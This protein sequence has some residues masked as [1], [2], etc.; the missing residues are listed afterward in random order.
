MNQFVEYI[1]ATIADKISC[2]PVN[3]VTQT[4]YFKN[5]KHH[6]VIR[7]IQANRLPQI[8]ALFTSDRTFESVSRLTHPPGIAF[9]IRQELL[10]QEIAKEVERV[11]SDP[12]DDVKSQL[13]IFIP[14]HTATEF[15]QS[16]AYAS[17][18]A[19]FARRSYERLGF[20]VHVKCYISDELEESALYDT[21]SHKTRLDFLWKTSGMEHF[22]L[23]L[24]TLH[25]TSSVSLQSTLSRLKEIDDSLCLDGLYTKLSGNGQDQK[26]SSLNVPSKILVMTDLLLSYAPT[27]TLLFIHPEN[28]NSSFLKSRK[29]AEVMGGC[30]IQPLA[31]PFSKITGF[32]SDKS[33]ESPA[34]TPSNLSSA[35]SIAIPHVKSLLETSTA[36][37]ECEPTITQIS[38]C[39]STLCK[40]AILFKL[41]QNRRSTPQHYSHK[42][43]QGDIG[44]YVQYTIA[45]IKGIARKSGVKPCISSS[46]S[47]CTLPPECGEIACILSQYQSILSASLARM[48]VSMLISYLCMLSKKVTS[49]TYDLRV[50]GVDRGGAERLGLFM[51]VV[52]VLEHGLFIVGGLEGVAWM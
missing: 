43:S 49:I 15:I 6:L 20:S 16:H 26:N 36:V 45:K 47:T 11:C 29:L 3:V 9:C 1:Q 44:L 30:T 48:E 31:F 5:E 18:L 34:S 40:T 41:F 27:D 24:P 17:F 37:Q 35:I 28:Y 42:V 25:Q 38:E 51:L 4:R 7:N 46:T 52:R 13:F 14:L 32:L 10:I 12:A 8:I 22:Q 21:A 33:S 39:A 50:K 23:E 19:N 2:D